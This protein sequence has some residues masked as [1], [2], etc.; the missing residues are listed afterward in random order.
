MVEVTKEIKMERKLQKKK[1]KGAK[2]GAKNNQNQ[3]QKQNGKPQDPSM[4][5]PQPPKVSKYEK[6]KAER[7]Q[8]RSGNGPVAGM[9][10]KPEW[11]GS[12]K[13]PNKKQKN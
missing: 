8:K 2:K 9:K 12:D 7:Q 11:S 1:E 5:I 10:R 13:R 6:G 4:Y 3:A